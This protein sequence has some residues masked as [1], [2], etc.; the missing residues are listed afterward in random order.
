MFQLLPVKQ[1]GSLLFSNQLQEELPHTVDGGIEKDMKSKIDFKKEFCCT[2][3]FAQI[4]YIYTSATAY[5]HFVTALPL[6][7]AGDI[8]TPPPNTTFLLV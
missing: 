6:L 8:Q 2:H 1:L 3:N 5:I 7:H 4:N